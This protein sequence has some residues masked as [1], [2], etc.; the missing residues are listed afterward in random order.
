[1][2]SDSSLQLQSQSPPNLKG[3]PL[4]QWVPSISNGN[5]LYY[6]LGSQVPSCIAGPLSGVIAG[7][8]ADGLSLDYLAYDPGLPV[9]AENADGT[10]VS[11][12]HGGLFPPFFPT[13]I[14]RPAYGSAPRGTYPLPVYCYEVANGNGDVA[15][16]T[17][18]ITSNTLARFKGPSSDIGG[19][20]AQCSLVT[21]SV[22]LDDAERLPMMKAN[23]K[24]LMQTTQRQ[25]WLIQLCVL[26]R[27]W[28]KA[29]M[30]S[31]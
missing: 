19:E 29:S 14:E 27:W 21:T 15:S 26:H 31:G 20:L 9:D 1:M 16:Y 12:G 6:H 17:P 30:L 22:F 25:E 2:S 5:L 24:S 11:T 7:R 3:F 10:L 4:P 13:M 23:W 8:P 18:V 28:T